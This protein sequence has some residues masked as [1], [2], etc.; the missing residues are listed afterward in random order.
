MIDG[1]SI[2]PSHLSVIVFRVGCHPFVPLG[3][4]SSP[5]SP[6]LSPGQLTFMGCIGGSPSPLTSSS[7][8]QW[9][10]P[11]REWRVGGERNPFPPCQFPWIDCLPH[12]AA[13]H[14]R[15]Q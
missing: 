13:H 7:V 14:S 10:A 15:F 9:D 6:A 5:L 8:G 12:I 1:V 4:F 11:A 3:L 2:L